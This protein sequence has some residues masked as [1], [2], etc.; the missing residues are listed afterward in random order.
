MNGNPYPIARVT[1]GYDEFYG[2]NELLYEP[3]G[4]DPDDAPAS[5][6]HSPPGL[7]FHLVP[8]E[9]D[10][11][12]AIEWE[13][14]SGVIPLMGGTSLD[15]FSVTLGGEDEAYER[16]HWSI[17]TTGSD[18]YTPHTW[19]ILPDGEAKLSSSSIQAQTGVRVR[20]GAVGHSVG[21]GFE[22]VDGARITVRVY[23]A[24]G[25]SVRI[26]SAVY[27]PAG[28]HELT[29][30]GRED[31]GA[32]VPNGEYFVRIWAP[33]GLRQARVTLVRPRSAQGR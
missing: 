16:G 15:G 7:V 8:T 29:W 13:V 6:T 24:S 12:F 9:E 31:S 33:Q 26:L 4:W 11:L 30:D 2:V 14:E 32:E 17:T 22:T 20:T 10:S 18:D 19:F 5:G 1:L 27:M 3:L 23:D 25:K 21:I 28:A